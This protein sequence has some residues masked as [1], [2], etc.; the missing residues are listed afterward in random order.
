MWR[1]ESRPDSADR[2][3]DNMVGLDA[4]PLASLSISMR[5]LG[6]LILSKGDPESPLPIAMQF[7]GARR[8]P[9]RSSEI[10]I[11]EG[12]ATFKLWSRMPLARGMDKILLAGRADGIFGSLRRAGDD[13]VLNVTPLFDHEFETLIGGTA[14]IATKCGGV[15]PPV[16]PHGR[17][18][19]T[20]HD[21]LQVTAALES[22]ARISLDNQLVAQNEVMRDWSA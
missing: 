17:Y 4:D 3:F 22:A 7:P 5:R 6:M 21:A 16:V 19:Q 1:Q 2:L 9:H 14:I 15:L 12:G 20:I 18:E 13:V 10:N 8:W 11:S